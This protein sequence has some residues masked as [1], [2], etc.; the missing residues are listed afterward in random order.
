MHFLPLGL[1]TQGFLS[2]YSN[3]TDEPWWHLTC[4]K[5]P[6]QFPTGKVQVASLL[7]PALDYFSLPIPSILFTC[8]PIQPCQVLKDNQHIKTQS[9]AKRQHRYYWL[10]KETDTSNRNHTSS[11]RWAVVSL[12]VR[13]DCVCNQ[14]FASPAPAAFI[15]ACLQ[16][17]RRTTLVTCKDVTVNN[18][19][20]EPF[21]ALEDNCQVSSCCFPIKCPQ[22]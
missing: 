4:L 21:T 18:R 19:E 11:G 17:L 15:A 10:S 1:I 7:F 13:N 6:S 22:L 14:H 8:L 2:H 9:Y 12:S 5:K 3:R 16:H 20:L